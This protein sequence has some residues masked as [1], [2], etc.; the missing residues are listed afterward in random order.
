MILETAAVIAAIAAVVGTGA[1]MMATKASN[2]AQEQA[3]KIQQRQAA[4]E[5]SRRARRAVAERRMMQAELIQNSATQDARTSSSMSGAT[6]S[7]ST[8]TAANIGA[9]NTWLAGDVGMNKAL[10]SGARTAARWNTV[11]GVASAAGS[12]AG[13]SQ[14]GNWL[15]SMQGTATSTPATFGQQLAH[16]NAWL[17]ANRAGWQ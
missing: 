17:N 10:I 9:A 8:Q 14:F 12:I 3:S 6:G 15:G 5:N 2:E 13:T 11:A 1:T 16:H 7:L 4:L